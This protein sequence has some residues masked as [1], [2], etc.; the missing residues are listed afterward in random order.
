[1]SNI[2][3]GSPPAPK[4]AH[5]QDFN[6][7]R[8]IPLLLCLKKMSKMPYRWESTAEKCSDCSWQGAGE[9][10]LPQRTSLQ[11]GLL[12]IT[13]YPLESLPRA[14]RE[15][16]N[17]R[18]SEV[19]KTQQSAKEWTLV[20]FQ[21][22]RTSTE[23]ACKVK[24]SRE[25]CSLTSTWKR[26]LSQTVRAKACSSNSTMPKTLALS[27]FSGLKSLKLPKRKSRG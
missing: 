2:V 24:S 26:R 20:M 14:P 27:F 12:P 16:S 8:Q 23:P 6:D 25:G 9:P 10:T 22:I 7:L 5:T 3:C 13:E 1:M 18:H 17:P 4:M 11:L 19:S 21:W 15:E